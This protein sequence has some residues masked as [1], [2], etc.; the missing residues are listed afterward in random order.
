MME[1]HIRNKVKEQREASKS[2]MCS[3]LLP[4]PLLPLFF[5]K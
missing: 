4:V 2:C 3:H 1:M 5:V